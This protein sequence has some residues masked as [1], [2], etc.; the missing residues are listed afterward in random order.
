[1]TLAIGIL[2]SG[3]G[4]NF[5]AIAEAIAERRLDAEIRLLV[6]NRPRARV[7]AKA[8]ARGIA[9]RVIEH[10]AFP[11]REAF[12]AAVADALESCGV[13][14]VAMAGFDRVVSRALLSRFPARVLNIHPALL[15]AF[16]GSDAQAQA[17]R[18]GVTIAGATVHI[19]DEDVDH[20]PIVIQAAVPVTAGEDAEA[21]RRR[22]LAQEHRIYPYAIQLFAEKRVRVEDRCVHID[23]CGVPAEE[24]LISPP[25]PRR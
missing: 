9:T 15:P 11:G 10:E 8:Q 24:S 18:Y 6:C 23:G 25:L 13:E 7:L 3:T 21:I 5:D 19:V 2:A 16:R 14:L 17:A 12:D 20:G 1:V 22:I 4:T